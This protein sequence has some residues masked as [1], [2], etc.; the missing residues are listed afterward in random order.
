MTAHDVT[1]DDFDA[2]VTSSPI[3]VIVD[4]WAPWCG[5]CRALS[6]ILDRI[7]A[8][9]AGRVRVVKVNADDEP[10]LAERFGVVS[11]P[12]IKVFAHGEIVKTISGARPKPALEFELAPIIGA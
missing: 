2:E 3:P 6:P 9:R 5:P 1:T 10:E 8:E 12:T 11:I 4:F 7:A